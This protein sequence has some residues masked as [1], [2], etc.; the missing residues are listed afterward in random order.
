MFSNVSSV[1]VLCIWYSADYNADVICACSQQWCNTLQLTE[2]HCNTL[3]HTATHCTFGIEPMHSHSQVNDSLT[4]EE[5][6]TRHDSWHIY[7]W[8]DVFMCDMTYSYV[9]LRICTWHDSFIRDMMMTHSYATWLIHTW[10]DSFICDVTHNTEFIHMRDSF[11]RDMTN[12][13]W[14]IHMC[15]WCVCNMVLRS[16]KS[17]IIQSQVTI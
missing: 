6:L 17:N 14:L 7:M 11:T 3:Q 16:N 15:D 4:W 1:T 13:T 8:Y 2:T 12:G 10:G 9:T 5:W